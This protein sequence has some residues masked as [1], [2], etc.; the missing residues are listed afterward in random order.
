MILETNILKFVKLEH[1]LKIASYDV[2]FLAPPPPYGQ[3]P[4][5]RGVVELS[6]LNCIAF[7]YVHSIKSRGYENLVEI[8][9][10]LFDKCQ[11][12]ICRPLG[13]LYFYHTVFAKTFSFGGFI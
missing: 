1:D 12:E 5:P 2:E 9:K 6:M 8:L 7:L 4:L 3:C 10:T 11:K 13:Y